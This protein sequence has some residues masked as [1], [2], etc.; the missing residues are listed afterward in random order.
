MAGNGNRLQYE[1]SPYLLQ[2]ASNPVDWFAWSDEAFEQARSQ[3]KPV[4]LSIG[5]AT[6]HWCH[7]M[8][9]ESFEDEQVAQLMN[10]SFI[11]I[12]VDREERPDIDSIYM[13]VCQMLTGRGGW[14]LNVIMTPEGQ[15]FFAATYIPKNSAPGRI[16]MF[17]LIPRIMGAWQNRRAE[18]DESAV[19]IT[20]AVNQLS[21]N[22]A[23]HPLSRDSLDKAYNQLLAHY[24]ETYG[25]FA[26]QPKFPTPHNLTFLMRYA[27]KEPQ[28]R[29][30][31]M[32]L[33]TLRQMALGGVYD[34]IGFGFHRYSTDKVW[35]LPHFEKM[36][37]DQALLAMAYTEAALVSDEPLFARV[38]HE[39]CSYVLRDMTDQQG[40]F[41]SAEDADSE[42]E[43]GKFYIW[44]ET[45]LL[46]HLDETEFDFFKSLFQ[47]KSEGNFADEATGQ[48]NG[49]NI[50]YLQ[51]PLDTEKQATF[52]EIR[53]KLFKEREER[54]HPLKDDKILTDFNG[55]MISALARA[56]QALEAPEYIAAA[57]RASD[58]I[59]KELYEDGRLYHRYR[60][61][62]AAITGL[63]DDYSFLIWGQLDLYQATF[64]TH[65]LQ[66]ALDLQAT[67]DEHFW[68]IKNGGYFLTADYAEKLITRS[69]D[70]YDGAVPSGNSVAML[71]L[72]R[73]NKFT[74]REEMLERAV[75]LG[76]AFAGS[77]GQAPSA[78]N[79][80][81]NAVYFY[82]EISYELVITAGEGDNQMLA[83][84]QKSFCPNMVLHYVNEN[85][86]SQL[87]RLAPFTAE[88]K[89]LDGQ[90]TAF[91]C[92]DFSCNQPTTDINEMLAALK[93]A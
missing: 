15:P 36:L 62:E 76:A 89:S 48:L 70:L 8:E 32:A 35:K 66:T 61:G 53:E 69:K 17:E 73:L 49:S 77:V 56:G 92:R 31:T 57:A 6:C 11:S 42:G 1:K 83:A 25:G 63:L 16:G 47:I 9:R 39:I 28:S 79:Q 55:L 38:A 20:R 54:I 46:Q 30:E 26:E 72:L 87:A 13:G 23:G 75:Q 81:M 64:K 82:S 33:K 65:Y 29:A 74:G 93:T 58:F 86:R 19:K 12:K 14:P 71:N 52:T 2:H 84:L 67:L 34:H 7:V 5:Y 22:Q 88:M 37:Y 18:V 44:S 68:D 91:V 10:E 50:P 4:F 51:E 80:L 40:G 21:A 78:Y 85:N 59:L 27:L 90:A 3:N 45:E 41:Y 43:E 24:D 60:D